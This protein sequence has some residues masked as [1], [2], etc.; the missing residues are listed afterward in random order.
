MVVAFLLTNKVYSP[1]YVLWLLPLLILARPRWRDWL[2]FTA[3]ELIYFG[4]I[5]WHL[6]GVLLTPRRQVGRP[7]LLA[8]A[9]S[10][11]LLRPRRWVVIMVVRDALRPESRPR[12]RRRGQTTRP[13]ASSTGARAGWRPG[14]ATDPSRPSRAA[15]GSDARAL[16]ARRASRRRALRGVRAG[17]AVPRPVGGGSSSRRGSPAAG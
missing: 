15:G 2:I 7:G 1:Q 16:R 4:A 5:W 12:P 10:I 11:R 14:P 9:V 17:R 13:A 3:G 8:C 6:G